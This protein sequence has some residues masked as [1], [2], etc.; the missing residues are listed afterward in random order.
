MPG[1]DRTGPL[2]QGPM[3][4]G[5]FGRCGQG[6]AGLGA[7]L[8]RGMGAGRGRGFGRGRFGLGGRAV[9]LDQEAPEAAVPEAR[10]EQAI[11]A[12]LE[13]IE[14]LEAKLANR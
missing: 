2:G 4:G 3:T 1:F 13:R 9:A 12:L 7:G 8:G 6:G 10:A 11:D 14:R 5:G